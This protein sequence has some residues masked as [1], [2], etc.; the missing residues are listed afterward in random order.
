MRLPSR[1]TRRVVVVP[2]L[3]IVLRLT[4]WT[5]GCET[6]GIPYSVR[7]WLLHDPHLWRLGFEF[8]SAW[9]AF[10]GLVTIAMELK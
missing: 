7:P 6:W 2:D 9:E 5:A 3:W 8:V 10:Y 1:E 4:K